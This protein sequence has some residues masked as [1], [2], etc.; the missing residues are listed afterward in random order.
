MFVLAVINLVSIV[1]YKFGCSMNVVPV[2]LSLGFP[3]QANK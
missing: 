3:E 2:G 1:F